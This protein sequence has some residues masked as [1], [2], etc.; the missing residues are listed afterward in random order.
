MKKPYRFDEL[1]PQVQKDILVQFEN[2]CEEDSFRVEECMYEL[3][4]MAYDEILEILDNYFGPNLTEA[5]YYNEYIAQL[6]ED[7]NQNGLKCPPVENEGIHRMLA[8]ALLKKDMPFYKIIYP[9]TIN[10]H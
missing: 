5:I 7:I 1:D 3:T 10:F 6:A 9:K 8:F 4:T 2:D